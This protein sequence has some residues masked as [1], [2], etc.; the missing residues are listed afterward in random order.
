MRTGDPRLSTTCPECA[1]PRKRT[2]TTI[3]DG[4][5]AAS[6]AAPCGHP[7]AEGRGGPDEKET[8]FWA[9]VSENNELGCLVGLVIGALLLVG[10]PFMF[11]GSWVWSRRPL[12]RW[13]LILIGAVAGIAIVLWLTG[14]P[15]G[16]RSVR[17]PNR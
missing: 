15:V 8:G 17:D 6:Y 12:T 4:K 13:L 16:P 7:C 10:V 9:A 1:Q 3:V 11:V 14:N 5:P 2:G